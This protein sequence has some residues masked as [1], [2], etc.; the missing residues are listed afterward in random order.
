MRVG[1][2]DADTIR[3][4]LN[5]AEQWERELISCCTP[6]DHTTSP[7]EDDQATIDNCRE[8]IRRFRDVARRLQRTR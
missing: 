6:G 2:R 8:N 3:L 5:L 1:V 7:H 4:A